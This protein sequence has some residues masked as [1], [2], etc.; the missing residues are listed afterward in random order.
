[1]PYGS[2]LGLSRCLGPGECLHSFIHSRRGKT[3]N[4]RGVSAVRILC[5]PPLIHTLQG[6]C[7]SHMLIDSATA[8]G[9]TLAA[10]D[11]EPAYSAPSPLAPVKRWQCAQT[12]D[13]SLLCTCW[14][15]TRGVSCHSTSPSLKPRV[16]K[17]PLPRPCPASS[18]T[19]TPPAPSRFVNCE[20]RVRPRCS[21]LAPGCP[22]SRIR[23][24][25][26]TSVWELACLSS[27]CW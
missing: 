21:D 22:G 19:S 7:Q 23:Y 6:V 25:P 26:T 8:A 15:A 18:L 4:D 12:E 14:Q 1:M 10:A 13:T 11:G 2:G 3:I 20:C 27:T 9:P 24:P 17:T 16:A 5:V